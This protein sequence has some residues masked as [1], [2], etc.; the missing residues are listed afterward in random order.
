MTVLAGSAGGLAGTLW[1][2]LVSS[3]LLASRP[4]LRAAG[5]R[6]DSGWRVLHTAAL[7]GLCGAAAGLLFWLGWGLAAFSSTPWLV[8]G[9]TYGVLLWFATALPALT[10][11]ALRVPTLRVASVVLAIEA[12]VAAVSVGLLCAFVWHRSA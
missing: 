7:Y 11:L 10:L 9:A 8:V 6:P 2:S 12:L 4:E 3:V 1:G 5:W